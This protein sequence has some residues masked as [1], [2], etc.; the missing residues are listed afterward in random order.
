MINWF[1]GNPSKK[2]EF[3]EFL[4]SMVVILA[5][6]LLLLALTSLFDGFAEVCVVLLIELWKVIFVI[7]LG[8]FFIQYIIYLVTNIISKD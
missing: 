5:V 2:N 1:I 8:I 7:G 4:G 6:E 3:F